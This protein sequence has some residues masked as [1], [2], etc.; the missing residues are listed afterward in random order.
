MNLKFCRTVGFNRRSEKQLRRP[1]CN[2][3]KPSLHVIFSSAVVWNWGPLSFRCFVWVRQPCPPPHLH[4]SHSIKFKIQVANFRGSKWAVK[5][6][7]P[8]WLWM[9]MALSH[10][11]A[12]LTGMYYQHFI[13]VATGVAP[14]GDK[15]V[16]FLKLRSC[17][18]TT[19]KPSEPTTQANTQQQL[20]RWS[21]AS[22]SVAA[23]FLLSPLLIGGSEVTRGVI[24]ISQENGA[25]VMKILVLMFQ[26]GGD[27]W[28]LSSAPRFLGSYICFMCMAKTATFVRVDT[29]K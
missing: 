23:L 5:F 4:V 28:L 1:R 3:F 20:E 10:F 12:S 21:G 9:L 8:G 24:F 6:L 13:S 25:A 26:R 7:P 2:I 18:N 17:K 22:P 27:P 15:A 29:S 11:P 16:I 14:Q 19:G